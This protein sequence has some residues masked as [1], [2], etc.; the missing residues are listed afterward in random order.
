MSKKIEELTKEIV[1]LE[2][3]VE[4]LM[5]ENKSLKSKKYEGL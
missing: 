4:D 1:K 5:K 2:N 3:R